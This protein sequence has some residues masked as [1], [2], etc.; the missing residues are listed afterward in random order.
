MNASQFEQRYL[1]VNKKKLVTRIL[2]RIT[3][4]LAIAVLWCWNFI[5]QM[6]L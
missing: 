1:D 3:V 5:C 2:S 4:Y 6:E